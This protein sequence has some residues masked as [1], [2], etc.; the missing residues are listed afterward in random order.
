MSTYSPEDNIAINKAGTGFPHPLESDKGWG[1][2]AN[3]WEIID[4]IR[5]YSDWQKGLAFTGGKES[6][7]EPC[8]WRQATIN[9]G[10]PK[11]FKAVMVWYHG[12]D[13]VPNTYKIQHWDGASWVNIFSTTNGHAY[14]KYPAETPSNWWE[15]WSTPT[16]NTFALVTSSKVRF[17]FNNCD[18]THGWIY[19]FEV[20]GAPAPTPTPTPTPTST[21]TPTPTPTPTST[22]IPTSKPT[23]TPVSCPGVCVSTSQSCPSGMIGQGTG[24]CEALQSCYRCGF[25]WAKKC[26]NSIPQLCCI[27]A[28]RPTPTSTPVPTPTP[29]PTIKPTPTATP[30]PTPTPAPCPGYCVPTWSSCPSNTIN[31]G[32]AG[33][34]SSQFCCVPIPSCPYKCRPATREGGWSK[35]WVTKC[36]GNEITESKFSCPQTT[37]CYSCGFMGMRKCCDQVSSICC[38]PK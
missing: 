7:V 17:T 33:C 25:F 11:T 35:S 38:R 31:Q 9:F 14:L 34:G 22:P 18:I 2:G 20:Y 16:E 10:E 37:Q 5:T 19:E 15:S 1:G 29:T 36:E 32:Y 3:P 24:G 26:C 28:P 8:G 21:P 4:G 30:T 27:P 6:Y 23:P 13:Q 12:L